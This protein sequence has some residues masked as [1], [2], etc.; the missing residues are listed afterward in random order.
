[1]ISCPTC[2]TSYP[3]SVR[4]C[5]RDGTVLEGHRPTEERF[6]GAVLHG[7]YRLDS[8]LSSGGMGA[9]FKATHVMLGK[10]V[11]VKLIKADLVTSPDMVR[12]F[13]REARA[14]TSLNHPNIVGV[15]DLGQTEDGT[16]YIAMELVDGTSLK[17]VIRESGRIDAPRIVY[18]LRQIASALSLAHR[19]QIIHRDLKPQNV[20][21]TRDAE[22][23]EIAKLLDFGIA[24]TFDEKAT[25]LTQTGFALGTPQYMSPEQAMGK[26]VDGRSDLY[27]LGVM[28]YEMLI[29]EVPFSDPSAPAILVKH[30]TEVPA[31]PS[32][33]R[34]DLQVPAHLEAIAL[35]CLEKEPSRRYQ[36]ADEFIAAL[37]SGPG[38]EAT[39]P[40]RAPIAPLAATVLMP[41]PGATSSVPT[42]PAGF[43]P[44]VPATATHVPTVPP[45][46]PVQSPV[47][48]SSTAAAAPA[49]GVPTVVPTA[50]PAPVVSEPVAPP[51]PPS[52]AAQAPTSDTRPTV[53]AAQAAVPPATPSGSKS[54]L[55]IAAGLMFLLLAGGAGAYYMTSRTATGDTAQTASG[56]APDTSPTTA[57]PPVP[58]SN[59]AA[60]VPADPQKVTAP[61]EAGGSAPPAAPNPAAPGAAPAPSSSA[62]SA[63]GSAAGADPV[64]TSPPARTSASAPATAVVPVPPPVVSAPKLPDQPSVFFDCQGTGDLCGAVRSA[65]DQ[66][67]ESNGLGIAR[68]K[69]RADIVILA[70][71]GVTGETR[72]EMFTTR[73]YVLD[74][75][76]DAP[77]LD[78][79]V[80]MPAAR[81]FSFDARV[82]RERLNENARAMAVQSMTRVKDFIEKNR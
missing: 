70:T 74:V 61:V 48:S 57:L 64:R 17:E 39:I 51:P 62:S 40:L 1:M 68:S 44:A 35:K 47:A 67:I 46:A 7:K 63:T 69:D 28:L 80:G 9:V 59:T 13:Q 11:A 58:A 73:S 75:V 36:T 34:P 71:I 32:R 60:A 12:R 30:M 52:V 43:A 37:E 45:A 77:K 6:V 79:A 26:E 42:A 4:L 49:A 31:P 66:Q 72:D 23:R 21:L 3:P 41:P 65:F 27:S 10:P 16:L 19:H 2:G 18:I 78:K 20:M 14:A 8:Y 50:L 82:G 25:Q 54:G 76:G 55:A 53:P 22:G 24:K 29:G 56:T 81:S 38:M 5:P 15:H 33:K